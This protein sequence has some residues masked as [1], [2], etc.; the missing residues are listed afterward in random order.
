MARLALSF[1]FPEPFRGLTGWLGMLGP[2]PDFWELVKV[3]RGA[4][5]SLARHVRT[6]TRT[7]AGR[8]EGRKRK[9][10]AAS[11]KLSER[12]LH[13][14]SASSWGIACGRE[15]FRRRGL[16]QTI[17]VR[18][19]AAQKGARCGTSRGIGEK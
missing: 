8:E 11:G 5:G 13:A 7:V 3:Y 10:A 6:E 4:G 18:F 16:V 2:L 9:E 14:R 12:E 19:G 1:F 17:G 15:K